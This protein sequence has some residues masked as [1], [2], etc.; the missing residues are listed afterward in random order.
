MAW[1]GCTSLAPVLALSKAE[2]TVRTRHSWGLPFVDG[3]VCC[4][5]HVPVAVQGT[6]QYG[7]QTLPSKAAGPTCRSSWHA[8]NL[9]TRRL[10]FAPYNLPPQLHCF[11]LQGGVPRFSCTVLSCRVR[12]LAS[13]ASLHTCTSAV[14]GASGDSFFHKFGMVCWRRHADSACIFFTQHF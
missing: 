7:K 12:C 5:A 9:L 14:Y 2:R 10:L 11:K 13:A 4:A 1:C 3:A 8:P 6:S